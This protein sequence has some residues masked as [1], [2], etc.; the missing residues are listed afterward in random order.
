MVMNMI[1]RMMI[2]MDDSHASNVTT[3]AAKGVDTDLNAL[4]Q[5]QMR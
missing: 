4:Q 5:C 3:A 1:A 2:T